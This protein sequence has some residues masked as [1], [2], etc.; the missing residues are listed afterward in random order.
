V[1]TVWRNG[2][3]ALPRSLSGS[4][5]TYMLVDGTSDFKNVS[6]ANLQSIF[7]NKPV[8]QPHKLSNK[9]AALLISF[10]FLVLF[11]KC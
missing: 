6:T 11:W 7:K 10:S 1:S 8:A 5:H 3:A 4:E 9:F 2:L